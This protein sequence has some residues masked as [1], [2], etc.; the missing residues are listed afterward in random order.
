MHRFVFFSIF[1]GL[2][3][4]NCEKGHLLTIAVGGAPNEL[5]YWEKLIREFEERTG[6]KVKLIR[7]P[8]DTDQRRQSLIIPLKAKKPD[9]DVFLMDIAWLGGFAAS[10]WLQ[11]LDDY[12]KRDTFDLTKFF[13]PVVTSVDIY[14]GALVAL[15]VYIDC[16]LLYYRK[17]LLEKYGCPV[18]RTWEELLQVA[19]LIQK[20]ERTRNPR[21][22]GFVWQGAQYE[23]LVCNF[24]EFITSAGGG[25]FDSLGNIN[26]CSKTNIHALTFMKDLIHKYKIS[27][28]NTYTEMKEEEVRISFQN[29]DALFERNWP[30]AWKLHESNDSPVKGKIGV[31]LL[32]AFKTGKTASA[33]GGWH[34]GISAYSDNKEQAWQLVKFIL[35]YESQKRLAIDLG[36]NPGREDVYEDPELKHNLPH[37]NVLKESFNHAV[38]RPNVPY[39]TR[40]SQILQIYVNAAISGR[41]EP[42]EALKKAEEKMREIIHTYE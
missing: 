22:Y 40:L 23:G 11:A 2:I 42:E 7:Q 8:T 12:V 25:L 10:G 5:D 26:L 38:A 29:G 4:L 31:T 6:I 13:K 20:K 33:L 19:T 32:P 30:Y 39:Y 35:S 36:W 24:L 3:F 14:E 28:P 34:I 41:I 15:P 16:G 21:F 17:D 27:P 9:P 37:I 18:P 1:F